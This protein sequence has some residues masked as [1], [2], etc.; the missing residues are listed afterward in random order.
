[1]DPTVEARSGLDVDDLKPGVAADVADQRE[2]GS[3]ANALS[4]VRSGEAPDEPPATT[5]TTTEDRPTTSSTTTT[6]QAGGSTTTAGEATNV[7][8][9]TAAK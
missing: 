5:T 3:L 6:T 8:P 4:F 7:P 2:F 9:T 1:F